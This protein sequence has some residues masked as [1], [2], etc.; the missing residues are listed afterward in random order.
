MEIHN[1]RLMVKDYHQHYGIDYDEIF[2]SLTMLKFIQ[3]ILVIA[4]HLDYEIWQMNVKTAFLNGE[5]E[6]MVYM[7]QSEDFIS[8]DKSKICKLQ[9]SI[10]ELKQA[11]QS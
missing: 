9:R 8:T 10:Y 1:V 6:E 2:F 5:L 3:I 4:A 7:I 11:S